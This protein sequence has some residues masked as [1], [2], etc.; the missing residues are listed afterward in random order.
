MADLD[1]QR[2]HARDATAWRGS[3]CARGDVERNRG[4]DHRAIRARSED[5]GCF[6]AKRRIHQRK[7]EG[8]K[9]PDRACPRQARPRTATPRDFH[10]TSR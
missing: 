9:S 10:Y 2:T 6:V 8:F 3:E 1:S 4:S 5:E 7:S